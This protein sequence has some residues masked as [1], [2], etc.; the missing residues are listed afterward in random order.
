MAEQQSP[1]PSPGLEAG[2]YEVI[3]QRLDRHG[4]TLR[5]RL[6]LLNAD[7]KAE[8]GGIDTTLLATTRLTT[9]N[10]CVP[11][12]MIAIGPRRFMF[13]YNVHLGL[14][15][16]M[17]VAD[18]FA[19]YDYNPDDHT[20]HPNRDNLLA[21]AAFA[22]DFSYLY[23][24]YKNASFLKFH[25][26]GP[27]L[28]LAM[29]A[30]RDVSEVKTFKWLVEEETG[31]LRY[32]GSRFD[33]E[34]VF[35]AHQ[36][37]EWRKVRREMYRHG[38]H[39]HISIEDRVFVECTGGDLTVKVEN[40]TETGRGI[41]SEP[42]ENPDQTLDDAEIHFAIVG[43]LILMKVLPYQEKTWRYLVFNERTRE[44]H[45]IDSIAESCVLLP[46]GH[47]IL[48]PH[49]CVLQT[50]T[51]KR[52]DTGL[53]P[54]KFE[55]RL[56]AENGEDTLFVFAHVESGTYLLLSY[57]LI[58]QAI[59]TPVVCHGYSLFPSGELVLFQADSEPRKHHALQVWR[60]PFITG[61]QP[62]AAASGSFLGKIGNAEIVRCMAEC[63]AVLT[64]LGKDDSFSGLYVELVRCT[65]DIVDSY[66]WIDRDDTHRLK[67]AL[68]DIK[69]AAEAALGEFEKVRRLR[70][71]AAD[72]TAQLK[73]E[74]SKSV[75]AATSGDPPD[76][77]GFVHLLTLL[78][79]LRGRIIALQEVRYVDPAETADMDAAVAE[80]TA[81]L[82]QN[83]VSFLLKPE[84]L[85]PYRRQITA[86]SELVPGLN[87]VADADAVDEALEKA[88]SDL[89]LL[90]GIVSDLKITDATETTRIIESISTLFASLNQSRSMLRNRRN[91]L[92]RQEGAAHFQAQ[93]SLL[94]QSVL[95]ALETCTAP[96]KCDEAL[97]R[98][99]LQ[100]E[101]LE[102]KFSGFD[103]YAAELIAKREEV[104]NAFDARRQSLTDA[105]NRQAQS[106]GQSAD[107]ILASVRSR[108][109]GFT[110]P[111]EVHAWLA[112]DAMVAR[113]RDLL[114]HLRELGDSVRADELQTKLKSLQQDSLKDIRDKADLHAGGGDVIQLG[115]HRFT[116]NR[117]PLELSILPRDGGLSY[118]LSGTR[119]F[120]PVSDASLDT[121]R[122][123]WDQSVVSENEDVY[124]AEY[125]AWQFAESIGEA[126]AA[127]ILQLEAAG[128]ASRVLDFM[129]QRYHEG[130]TK[131]VH[132]HD[133]AL[134]VRPLLEMRRNLGLLR[135]SPQARAMALLCWLEWRDGPEKQ[136][137]AAKMQAKGRMKALIGGVA[138][139]GADEL[140]PAVNAFLAR[141]PFARLVPATAP[142]A[143]A[144]CLADELLQLSTN[145]PSLPFT[146][147]PGAVELLR[148]FRRELTARRA[149]KGFEE[150][151]TSLAES[152]LMA[153]EIAMEWLQALHGEAGAGVLA[154][155]AALTVMGETPSAA[156]TPAPASQV[157]ITG[158]TGSHRRISQGTMTLDYHEFTDRLRAFTTGAVPAFERFQ[159]LKQ[160][161]AATRRRALRL[162]QF[163]AGVLSSFVRNRLLDEVYLPLIGANLAKQIGTAD[164]DS[165]TDRM[166]LLL[167]ISPPGYGKTTL[168]EYVANRLGITLVKINGPA[169]GHRVTSLDPA[170]A[171]NASAREEVLKLNLAL[172]M[173]DNVMIYLD[174]IQHTNPEFLQKFIS[175][176]D[177]TRRMEGV[178]R[179]EART[180]DLRGRRVAV[181]MAGNPYTEVGG[182]FQIPDMLANRA[183]T[184]NLGEILG[185]HT[186]AFKDSYI[187]NALTSN[188]ILSRIA[189]RSHRD[190][191]MVLKIAR[192]GDR[193]GIEFEGSY[194]PEEV[195]DAVQLMQHLLAV[196]ETILRVNAEY[197]RSA[198]TEDAY[199]T[200][201]PF[202]LQGS[203][204]N[205]NKITEKI[206]PLMTAAEV[207][208]VVLDHYRSEAQTLSHAAE[209][210][211]LKWREINGLLTD[212]EK[213]RWEDIRRTFGRNLL[214]GGN[215]DSDPVNR[216]AGHL[217][218]FSAGLEKIEQAVRQ[219]TLS[220][221]TI[222]HLRSIIDGLRAVPVLVEIKVQ[223]VERPAENEHPI[224]V[225]STV[226][227]TADEAPQA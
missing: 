12:D 190:A 149:A 51:V 10:N 136:A 67:D 113:L 120:E 74:V 97:A 25:R 109:A 155:A 11:R 80:G 183:D 63:Q 2:A 157:A 227:Q 95:N 61:E 6:E 108:L 3:R 208:S 152:P 104:Q 47:G 39:S 21:D 35:P 125:L 218:S 88:G 33:H 7:R 22:E 102:D 4:A 206:Q 225:E 71:S 41:Y 159:K 34:F 156:L 184:Y 19:V 133:A 181:V 107:R 64:L 90:T 219:P 122:S 132:D 49:G 128:I 17:K 123:V 83:C 99:M 193:E 20:V 15:T 79:S 44:A 167:L 202:K 110:K 134:I 65:G 1:P 215:G 198:A 111:D 194:S 62:H 59:A 66:F 84:A 139:N 173:G 73:E 37:F 180:Y 179:G 147:S 192:T 161:L 200:E 169:I 172:E 171:P 85:D 38:I 144:D 146:R 96:G 154:E 175:L 191:M 60:T 137:L 195:N 165:R 176:C 92:A 217:N 77:P 162:D 187:E 182:R 140:L 163:K 186:E 98:M 36:E 142:E 8:F 55:R 145:H 178:C 121:L 189:A 69:S 158:L 129:H 50:G 131:G 94:N 209:S 24:Y 222:G 28:Y 151:L 201:P 130:Y 56:T 203:Y 30:G 103:D 124:R 220:D 119:Y 168:M 197:I 148:A 52:F 23:R 32:L 87:R 213:Q 70:Q 135:H 118:H 18:V 143:V 223:P 214:T 57:N 27:H 196:R 9:D 42:V 26:I 75:R 221:Q 13:G 78:R 91:D 126:D 211:L 45:R 116:V 226:E 207:Q 48:F 14:R 185:A 101:E 177:G 199:R 216:I 212:H 114:T 72:Q 170:E 106:V 224:A 105:R 31:T 40:N 16:E 93:L 141:V 204:R 58:T 188:S 174:D 43:N 153:F 117:Q 166:G 164:A 82:S 127:D 46:D 54:M 138:G 112:G 150:S 5:Q 89:E 68:V 205:M 160:D 53:P 210:N 76:I 100:I 81:R 115:G 86:Q 29:Q